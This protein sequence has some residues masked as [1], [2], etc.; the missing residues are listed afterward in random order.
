[1]ETHQKLHCR[2]C[3]HRPR[4]LEWI[5]VFL[6]TILIHSLV[7]GLLLSRFETQSCLDAP[8]PVIPMGNPDPLKKPQTQF[9]I[10]SIDYQK[11]AGKI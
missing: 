2:L 4:C 6:A 10:E 7:L 5:Y 9:E 11:K 8:V 3:I 1:M